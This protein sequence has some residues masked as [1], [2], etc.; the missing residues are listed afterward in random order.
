M[1]DPT[2]LD[3]TN[4]FTINLEGT[5]AVFLQA[6]G[7]LNGDGVDD[8]ILFSWDNPG[9]VYVVFGRGGTFPALRNTIFLAPLRRLK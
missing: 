1:I 8:L 3:G 9:T 2:K 4:G 7:D 5:N 6:G